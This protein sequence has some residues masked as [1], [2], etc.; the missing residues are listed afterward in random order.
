M[1]LS[2][3]GLSFCILYLN[4][5]TMGYSFLDFVHFIISRWECNLFIVGI[6]FMLMSW[7]GKQIYEL[8]LRRSI[9]F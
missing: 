5:L 4:L 3:L 2:S 8:L 7:K 6:L 9:K 1:L